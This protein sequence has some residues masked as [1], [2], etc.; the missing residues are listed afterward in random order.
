MEMYSSQEEEIKGLWGQEGG[1]GIG[2]WR[3]KAVIQAPTDWKVTLCCAL[4]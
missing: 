2:Q 3:E 1:A 4:G